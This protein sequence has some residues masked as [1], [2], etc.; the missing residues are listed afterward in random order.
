MIARDL[1]TMLRIAALSLAIIV[2]TAL[3]AQ[4][5]PPK[6]TTSSSAWRFRTQEI[7]ANLKIGY[8]V[9]IADVNGDGKPDIVVADT[10]EVV[11]YENP[12][13]KKRLIVKNYVEETTKDEAGQP[14]V[15]KRP[16]IKEDNVCIAA[17]DIDGDGQIDF[18]LG[19]GWLPGFRTNENGTIQWLKRG[20]SLD[21]PWTVIPIGE[22]PMV[23]R[24]LFADLNGDGKLHLVVAPLMGRGSSKSGNWTDGRPVRILDYLIPADPVNGPWTP[25]VL[26]DTL[27][28]VHGIRA[29]PADR[30]KGSDI[31]VAS[32]D[33]ISRLAPLGSS[34]RWS[35]KQI[36][37][38]NQDAP[39]QARGS[40]EVGFGK[41]RGGS[42]FIAAIEPWHGN[43]VVIYTR[44]DSPDKPWDRDVKDSR[45]RWGHAI[46][47]ADLD[48]DGVDEVI[49]GVRDD[50]KVTDSY[51]DRRG[52]RIYRYVDESRRWDRQLIEPGS[53][54]VEALAVGDLNGDGRPDIVAVG[55]Q[56]GNVRIYWNE[57]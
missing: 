55:R 31:L 47:C 8:A 44:N 19:A 29:I 49:V 50:P 42:P 25:R 27:H 41:L 46:A 43:Q 5:E 16:L 12:D 30:R 26:D 33:G 7:D 18:A 34:E 36:G 9:V 3:I 28:V 37:A 2:P 54:A 52:I 35:V 10:D 11:W 45:L 51:P 48:G 57:K 21:E 1:H 4:P 22:E 20:K 15:I 40:S 53:V 39:T 17:A 14:K 6:T 38:G 32:Y 13:W 23:H 56:T 24:M